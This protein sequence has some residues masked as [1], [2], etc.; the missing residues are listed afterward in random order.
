M[1]PIAPKEPRVL[2]EEQK[3]AAK[4]RAK[5]IFRKALAIADAEAN[6]QMQTT[7]PRSRSQQ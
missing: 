5:M 1:K 4:R 6:K 3:E 7:P 2:T